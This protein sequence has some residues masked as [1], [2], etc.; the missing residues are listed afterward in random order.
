MSK[1]QVGR[2][3]LDKSRGVVKDGTGDDGTGGTGGNQ[4]QEAVKK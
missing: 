1:G 3:A 2:V 4:G